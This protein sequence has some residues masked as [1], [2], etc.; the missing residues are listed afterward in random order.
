MLKPHKTQWEGF[1]LTQSACQ[2]KVN[3]FDCAAGLIDTH[4]V[5]RFEIQVDDAF[6][7]DEIYS[8]HNLKHVFDHLSL[9]QLKVLVYDPL[10][11]LPSRDP[12]EHQ[13]SANTPDTFTYRMYC[14]ILTTSNRNVIIFDKTQFMCYLALFRNSLGFLAFNSS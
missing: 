2:S 11:Q 8:I 3:E 13:R 10:K 12:E 14:D 4:D 1:L 6:L 5:L 9:R 7:M